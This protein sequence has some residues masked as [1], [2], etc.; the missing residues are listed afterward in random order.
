MSRLIVHPGGALCGRGRVP[1]DKSISHR[2]L[3]LGA[4]ADGASHISGFLP[5]R[6]CLATLAC[7]RALGVPVEAHDATTLTVHGRGLRGLQAPGAPLNCVRSGTT[8]RL[9]A[10][11]LAGQSFDCTLTGDPQLLR[12]PMRRITEPLRRM[13]AGIEATDG[14]APLTIHGRR[15]H[16]YDHTLAV[17]SAQ[18]KSALLLAGLYADGPTTVRQLGPARDHTERM[19]AAMGAAI[20]TSGLNVT[21][22][23]S[24]ALSPLTLR[25]PG[26]LSSAAF[27]LIAAALLPGSEVTIERVGVNPTRTGLLDVL[28]AM[29]AGVALE[30][31]REQGGEPVADVTMRASDLTGVE[32]S[33]HTVVRMIDEFPVLA[34]AA[35]QAHGTTVVRDAAELRVKETDR[36]ATAVAELRVLGARIEPRPDGFVV[37]GPTTLRGGVVDSHGDHRLAMALAVA[38]LV[39]QG[40]VTIE[41]AECVPDSF[42][43]FVEFMRSLG[44]KIHST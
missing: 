34:V 17:A 19:L 1:G 13:G 22:V 24:A 28:R 30:D 29:G 23:S 10:G 32:V 26:D 33:G 31:E 21:L 37:E 3:L 27:P 15:L 35:T 12:R 38:G 6:D 11:I 7:L 14:H 4:L 40:E 42:P 44:A 9:L 2:A 16:G 36:I 20:K 41:N 18:V 25:I 39:A 5:S 43:G 8:M